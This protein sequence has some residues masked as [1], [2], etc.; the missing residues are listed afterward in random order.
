[1]YMNKYRRSKTS[2]EK[3]LRHQRQK[4]TLKDGKAS[5]DH[6]QAEF[7]L[8]EWPGYL[9]RPTDLLLSLSKSQ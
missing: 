3:T 2:T 5:P 1:M 7:M 9:K 8:L 4:K 6:G